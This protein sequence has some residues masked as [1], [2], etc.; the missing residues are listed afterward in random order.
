MRTGPRMGFFWISLVVENPDVAI[1]AI[2]VPEKVML[3][4]VL[5][6]GGVPD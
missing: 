2:C 1:P 5:R 6:E 3:A 4:L